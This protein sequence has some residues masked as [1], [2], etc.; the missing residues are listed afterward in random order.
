[1][2]KFILALVMLVFPSLA[3]ASPRARVQA[4]DKTPEMTA[5]NTVVLRG[6]VTS[7]SISR[8][9]R[10]INESSEKELYLFITSPGGS[11]I[12]GNQLV[13][14]LKTTEKK[15]TCVANIA[16]SMAFV[17]LQ[18]CENRVV[19]PHAIV[20]QHVASYGLRGEAPNNLS[21][22]KF[23]HRMIRQM[24]EAQAKR[25]GMS[26]K[27]FKSKIR[28]DWWLFG[29]ESVKSNVADR[30]GTVKCSPE[31]TKSR[32]KEKVQVF[33][34]T[35]DVVWSGCPLVEYP[36]KIGDEETVKRIAETPGAAS[37]FENLLKGYRVRDMVMEWFETGR[38][39][40]AF[41]H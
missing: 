39:P 1:M 18:A 40:F 38:N 9:I 20:M 23:L 33:I 14:L 12:A 36:V 3:M 7:S 8:V 15:I 17:I 13:Y 26:Y 4:E 35:I 21:R 6:E 25:I 19:L 5:K 28:N 32:I 37:A 31:L 10:Q 16:V 24:D 22:V 34:F 2:K 27:E 30:V 11:I 29:D 41:N